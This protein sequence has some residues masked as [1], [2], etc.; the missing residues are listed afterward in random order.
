MGVRY[1]RAKAQVHEGAARSGRRDFGWRVQGG[2]PAGG[3][4]QMGGAIHP[5]ARAKSAV[6]RPNC[7]CRSKDMG[8]GAEKGLH[9]PSC[10]NWGVLALA[11]SGRQ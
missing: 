8:G 11:E 10:Y 5:P 9:R 7:G 2:G 1:V 4:Q 6:Q 3:A